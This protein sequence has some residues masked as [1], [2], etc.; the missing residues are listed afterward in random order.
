MEFLQAM[1][2]LNLSNKKFGHCKPCIIF[3]EQVAPY[4]SLALSKGFLLPEDAARL[5]SFHTYVGISQEIQT[6][7]WYKKQGIEL[8]LGTYVNS[9]DVRHHMVKT[10]V[11]E[12][13]SYKVLIIGTGLKGWRI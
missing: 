5:P 3:Q 10:A 4:E 11:G 8:V 13:T 7:K 1:L 9:I 6:S 2:L 12:M